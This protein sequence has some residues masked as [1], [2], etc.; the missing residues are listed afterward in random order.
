MIYTQEMVKRLKETAEDLF[1]DYEYI[2]I[3]VQTEVFEIGE[4]D[5]VSH[6]WVDGIETE[7][8]LD[9]ICVIDY[10]AIDRVCKGMQSLGCGGYYGDHVAIIAGNHATYGEDDGE[11][12]ISDP[13]VVAVLA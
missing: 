7:E 5:H 4:I 13:A 6:V 3:R 12:I 1:Y 10:K 9:G 8:E 2:G 11:I